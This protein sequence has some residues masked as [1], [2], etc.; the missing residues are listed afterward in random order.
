[1]CVRGLGLLVLGVLRKLNE[2]AMSSALHGAWCIVT[3][4]SECSSRSSFQ[5]AKKLREYHCDA[6]A[7]LC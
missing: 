4:L 2:I 1:M 6:T 3:T 5:I 7:V